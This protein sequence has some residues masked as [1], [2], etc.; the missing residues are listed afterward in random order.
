LPG[1]RICGCTIARID[2]SAAVAAS[3]GQARGWPVAF[4]RSQP[5]P[6]NSP[7]IIG[8]RNVPGIGCSPVIRYAPSGPSPERHAP[9]SASA[10][11][12]YWA[13]AS[14]TSTSFGSPG[15]IAPVATIRSKVVT[16]PTM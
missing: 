13:A 10:A 5:W 4:A 16:Q 12:R 3:G 14:C 2:S 8:Y 15:G 9:T 6:M 11:A 1:P 7:S